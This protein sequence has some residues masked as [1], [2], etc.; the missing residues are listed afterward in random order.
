MAWEQPSCLGNGG[1]GRSSG[2]AGPPEEVPPA[3]A[4]VDVVRSSGW[5]VPR[6]L[7][8]V[9]R[10]K[11]SVLG[12]EVEGG[13]GGNRRMLSERASFVEVAQWRRR[14]R[15]TSRRESKRASRETESKGSRMV[16]RRL[17]EGG[18]ERGSVGRAEI[19]AGKVGWEDTEAGGGGGG[20]KEGKKGKVVKGVVVVEG[21]VVGVGRELEGYFGKEDEGGWVGGTIGGIEVEPPVRGGARRWW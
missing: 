3:P 5:L 13:G 17:R 11:N 10:Y 4:S 21:S 9:P 7:T 18:T 6:G 8:S 14:R 16:G 20:G 1:K 15:W 12:L 19:L 2:E